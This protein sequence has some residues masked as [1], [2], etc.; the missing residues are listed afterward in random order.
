MVGL[1]ATCVCLLAAAGCDKEPAERPAE[2]AASE[3]TS[4]LASP[5]T[6]GIAVSQKPCRLEVDSPADGEVDGVFYVS[7]KGELPQRVERDFGEGEAMNTCISF[8][9]A[10]GRLVS[11]TVHEGDCSTKPLA[12]KASQVQSVEGSNLV[13]LTFPDDDLTFH[14]V[15]AVGDFSFLITRTGYNLGPQELAEVKVE[16]RRFESLKLPRPD[17]SHT[18][19]AAYRDGKL[20]RVSQRDSKD[21]EV[22]HASFHYRDDRLVKVERKIATMSGGQSEVVELQYECADKAEDPEEQEANK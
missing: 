3:T 11:K 17:G 15:T 8:S 14:Y 19:E 5:D 10:N 2:Q 12:E 4:E 21:E 1:A 7:Y 20:I 13:A 22:G 16:E 6:G 9:Y 18:L